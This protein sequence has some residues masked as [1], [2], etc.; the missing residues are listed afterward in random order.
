MANESV[1]DLEDTGSTETDENQTDIELDEQDGEPDDSEGEGVEETDGQDVEIV[2]QG[3]DG[4]QPAPKHNGI[5]KRINKLNAKVT[6]AVEG[7]G[8]ASADLETERQKTKLLQLA[9][10]QQNK[11]APTGP[12][13][14]YDFDDGAKD[15]K[16]VAA[17]E[18]YNREFFD[19]EMTRRT[20][21]QPAPIDNSV[22]ERRQAAH[23]KAADKLGINDYADVEDVA[24]G[25]LGKQTTNHLIKSLDNSEKVM[26]WLGKNPARAESIAELLNGPDAVKGVLELG[27]LSAGLVAQPR[28]KR[29]AAPN[30]DDD[31]AGTSGSRNGKHQRGSAGVTYS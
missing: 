13:D 21:A 22:L 25:I 1:N 17:L 8:Q 7:Q 3:D 6:A 30:P 4:S 14:P 11:K 16:Y 9:L 19:A 5:Q 28:A 24:I 12:P 18:A 23:Y 10:D 26:Y 20:A 31:L 27:A 2:L 15:G 29:N